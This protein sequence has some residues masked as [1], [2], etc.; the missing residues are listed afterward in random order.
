M[1]LFEMSFDD[2][3]NRSLCD[4]YFL[5]EIMDMQHENL[6]GYVKN[7]IDILERVYS[8]LL[9]LVHKNGESVTRLDKVR[10]KINKL[11]DGKIFNPYTFTI[12]YNVLKYVFPADN[13]KQVYLKTYKI[14]ENI[15]SQRYTKGGEYNNN[16]FTKTSNYYYKKVDKNSIINTCIAIFDRGLFNNVQ[17]GFAYVKNTED[18]LDFITSDHII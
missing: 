3:N 18:N 15:L 2:E 11:K 10:N 12:S 6:D 4:S 13:R 7:V 9:K 5:N 1:R 14:F 16:T 17:I 8:E